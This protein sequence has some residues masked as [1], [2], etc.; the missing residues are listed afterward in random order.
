MSTRGVSIHLKALRAHNGDDNLDT[1]V[2]DVV[3]MYLNSPAQLDSSGLQAVNEWIRG[4]IVYLEDTTIRACPVE[5]R[6]GL[7]STDAGVW[8]PAVRAYVFGELECPLNSDEDSTGTYGKAVVPPGALMWVLGHA[9]SLAYDDG[10][11]G[12]VP[13]WES[14]PGAVETSAGIAD[15]ES[16]ERTA[17]LTTYDDVMTRDVLHSGIS[18]DGDIEECLLR[19]GDIVD[20]A[21]RAAFG[22]VCQSLAVH[23]TNTDID[24]EDVDRCIYRIEAEMMP[25]VTEKRTGLSLCDLGDEEAIKAAIPL[26]FSTG[27]DTLDRVARVLRILHIKDLRRLQN[28]IDDAIAAHQ[29]V[30]A[31]PRTEA[32]PKRR[33]KK[34]EKG[35]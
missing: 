25:F 28:V 15:A 33:R 24:V 5:A 27:D 32:G 18:I 2:P 13:A 30:T 23:Q 22:R 3:C 20:D 26:G 21:A 34:K 16:D 12:D 35:G 4:L 17:Q 6:N 10:R 7:K 11:V 9:V 14:V 29:Q 31:N 19:S 8:E 1:N